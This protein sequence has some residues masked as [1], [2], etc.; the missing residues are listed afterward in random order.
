[1]ETSPLQAFGPDP[2]HGV[3]VQTAVR[4]FALVRGRSGDRGEGGQ[5]RDP[6]PPAEARRGGPKPTVAVDDAN[7]AGDPGT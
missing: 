2:G 7:Q 3:P 1:M 5:N 6:D 4:K